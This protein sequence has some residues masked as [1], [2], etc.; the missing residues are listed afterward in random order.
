[1]FKADVNVYND[2][3]YR[4]YVAGGSSSSSSSSSRRML[5]VVDGEFDEGLQPS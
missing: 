2:Y 3:Q 4:E 1:M 5:G